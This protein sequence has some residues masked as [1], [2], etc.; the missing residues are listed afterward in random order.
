MHRPTPEWPAT[1]K[2]RYLR[3]E[4]YVIFG[5]ERLDIRDQ[6]WIRRSSGD[7]REILF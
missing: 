5:E 3:P 2:V 4:L 6:V 1:L 7:F